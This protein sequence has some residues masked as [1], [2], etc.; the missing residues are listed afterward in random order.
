[1]LKP[2]EITKQL[3]QIKKLRTQA[4]RLRAKEEPKITA[5][6]KKREKLET[7]IDELDEQDAAFRTT[8]RKAFQKMQDLRANLI[9]QMSPAQLE[10]YESEL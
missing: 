4:E 1:M 2:Q 7:M 10:R 6:L 5:R 8:E 3:K 9:Q